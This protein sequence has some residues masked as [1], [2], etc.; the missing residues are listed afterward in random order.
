MADLFD[1]YVAK[2]LSGGGGGSSDFSTAE[3]TIVNNTSGSL[4]SIYMPYI[5]NANVEAGNPDI[6]M[7]T[8]L[9]GI[10]VGTSSYN[11]VL[12]KGSCY[13]DYVAYVTVTGSM[14]VEIAGSATKLFDGAIAITGDC[15]IT[16][17]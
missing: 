17:S 9:G 5:L 6:A 3:V 8:F 11:A 7:P 12:Y 13:L 2:K 16:I 15:T 14:P 10:P 1:I 4:E